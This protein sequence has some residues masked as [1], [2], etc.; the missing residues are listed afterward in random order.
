[1]RWERLA[2]LR[3]PLLMFLAVLVLVGGV[4]TG[5]FMLSVPIGW[6]VLGVLGFLALAFLA[7]ATD[8]EV[9]PSAVMARVPDRM[10]VR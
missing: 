4:S 6:M 9:N 10:A 3:A 7:W 1:M 8:P 5:A 2:A